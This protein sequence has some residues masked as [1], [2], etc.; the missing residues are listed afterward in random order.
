M[1]TVDKY[2]QNF[3]FHELSLYMYQQNSGN[4]NPLKIS[5]YMVPDMGTYYLCGP[6]YL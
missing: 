5:T 1:A 6:G 2:M 4:I 3:I